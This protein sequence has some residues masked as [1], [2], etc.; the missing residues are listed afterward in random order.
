MLHIKKERKAYGLLSRPSNV[1]EFLARLPGRSWSWAYPC[2]DV[3]VYWPL[4]WSSRVI[5]CGKSYLLPQLP[6]KW[7][8]AS[9]L[10]ISNENKTRNMS[11]CPVCGQ[12]DTDTC[13]TKLTFCQS[14]GA[15][16]GCFR[17]E[18]WA[19][20]GVCRSH[21]KKEIGSVHNSRNISWTFKRVVT[22][23]KSAHSLAVNLTDIFLL[24]YSHTG[25]LCLF[26]EILPGGAGRKSPGKYLEHLSL[27]YI[28]DE[29]V[30]T[31]VPA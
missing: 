15:V 18:L 12:L 16:N 21:M 3:S 11:K 27:T 24:Y 20:H 25:S 10:A 23:R 4:S 5:T 26:L 1:I 13:Q 19:F 9:L 8:K 7:I 6:S 14:V 2:L 17:H 28:P 31:S 29:K 30:R 22:P